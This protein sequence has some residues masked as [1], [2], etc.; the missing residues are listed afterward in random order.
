MIKSLTKRAPKLVFAA[1]I[2]LSA[3]SAPAAAQ[4][5]GMAVVRPAIVVATSQALQTG[6]Q[7]ISST[8]ATQITQINQL[9]EQR[10]ALLRT[11][12]T[13]SNG[14]IEEADTNGDGNLDEAEQTR[15]PTLGQVSTLDQQIGALDSQVQ[16]AQV[17][18]V[19]QIAQQLSVSLQQV[20]T[21]RNVQVLLAPEAVQY[22]AEGL[23][24]TTLVTTNL[25]AR[26]PAVSI[27]P[28]AGWTPDQETIGF[29]QQVQQ[30]LGAL[31][32]RAQQEAAAAAPAPAA[33]GR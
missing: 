21:E 24:L 1:G 33:E 29:Y 11:I 13:N 26:L 15:N 12:D 4:I 17:F 5:N 22:G 30:I 19:N 27:T 28:T 31:I 32:A 2:A 7:L 16:M 23:D 25:N 10:Q 8:Y 18:V 3:L 20:V 6:Y 14:Q 9:N